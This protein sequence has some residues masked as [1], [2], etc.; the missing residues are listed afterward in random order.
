MKELSELKIVIRGAG[1][2]ASGVAHRLHAANFRRMLMLERPAPLAVR[3]GVCFCEALRCASVTV[4]GVEAVSAT[5]KF[6]IAQA[7]HR[8]KIPVLAD[9][10]G[11]S[12]RRFRWDVVVD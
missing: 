3:R 10:K 9:A 5:T 1:E 6:D 2:M 7:W 4:E 11:R 12:L 8:D